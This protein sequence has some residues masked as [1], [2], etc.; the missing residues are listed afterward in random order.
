MLEDLA[1]FFVDDVPGLVSDLDETLRYGDAV[2]AAQAVHSLKCLAE[3][4]NARPTAAL[5]ADVESAV[6][7][8][9]LDRAAELQPELQRQLA[10]VSGI[11]QHELLGETE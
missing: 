10:A 5:A 11:L 3:N 2:H 6:R 8:G 9:A 1:Q 7:R 4:F